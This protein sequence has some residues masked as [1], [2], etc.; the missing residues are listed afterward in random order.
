MNEE[1]IINGLIT[2]FGKIRIDTRW[3]LND[4][5]ERARKGE[6]IVKFKINRFR[7]EVQNGHK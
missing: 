2:V 4:Y 5:M 1:K 7:K 3:T 6:R